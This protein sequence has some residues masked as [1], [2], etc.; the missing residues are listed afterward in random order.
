[1]P[2]HTPTKKRRELSDNE[3]EDA[4]AELLKRSVEDVPRTGAMKEV[5]AKFCVDRKT[6]ARLWKR[7][8]EEQG[9]TGV[10]R[11]PSHHHQRGRPKRISPPR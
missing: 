3:R 4:V 8:K 10:Q 5:A 9:R 6:L 7:A 2:S 1:M 11:S